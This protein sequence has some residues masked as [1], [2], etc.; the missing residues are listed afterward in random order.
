[1]VGTYGERFLD[2]VVCINSDTHGRISSMDII[3]TNLGRIDNGVML[4]EDLLH[5]EQ[6]WY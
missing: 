6:W 2:E 1:V 5:V 3:Q 4:L